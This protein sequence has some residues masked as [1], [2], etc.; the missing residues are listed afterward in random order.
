MNLT[1]PADHF[2]PTCQTH[3]RSQDGFSGPHV[4]LDE[5]PV[6]KDKRASGEDMPPL[7]AEPPAPTPE[8][9]VTPDQARRIRLAHAWDLAMGLLP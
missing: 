4:L 8:P 9:V 3:N 6:C 2:C 1:Q 5:C 7:V